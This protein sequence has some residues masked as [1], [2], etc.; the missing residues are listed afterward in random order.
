[1]Q[2]NYFNNFGGLIRDIKLKGTTLIGD[3]ILI[4]DPVELN[5]AASKKYVD[6][7]FSSLNVILI[8]SG[9]LDPARIPSLSGDVTSAAGTTLTSL[10]NYGYSNDPRVKFTVNEKGIIEGVHPLGNS[11]IPNL[12]WSKI[13]SDKPTTL[14]GYGITD[15]LDASGGT[16]SV[17]LTMN[18][19]PGSAKAAATKGYVDTAAATTNS[20]GS[21]PGDLLFKPTD[22]TPIGY[23][24]CNGAMAVITTYQALFDAIGH[25]GSNPGGGYFYLPNLTDMSANGYNYFIKY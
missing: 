12:D 15:A 5:E 17:N 18:A 11:D 19:N 8:T 20:S 21:N 7:V 6:D 25:T 24:R 23:L 3:I 22:I 1:M 14:A 4:R 16:I 9:V 13:T 10:I 2:V